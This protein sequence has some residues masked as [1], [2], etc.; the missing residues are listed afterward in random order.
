VNELVTDINRKSQD[1]ANNGLIDKEK[2]VIPPH[3]HDLQEAD[4]PETQRGLVISEIAQFRERAAK[5]ER[6]KMRDVRESIPSIMGAPSG[7][8]VREWGK[9]Q[10]QSRG[11][12]TPQTPGKVPSAQQPQAQGK[13]PQGYS[14]PVGFV[15]AEGQG[16]PTG[17]KDDERRV[18]GRASKTDEEL[19]DER[20][21]ARRRDEEISFRDVSVSLGAEMCEINFVFDLLA[22]ASIRTSGTEP[23]PSHRAHDCT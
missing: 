1:A 2:Y 17:A 22:G 23:Y 15:R 21:E 8:K 6:E 5:R 18:P 7:P 13:G 12:D 11:P 16:S 3:L 9:P 4:L 20:K 10:S 14:K 19:E